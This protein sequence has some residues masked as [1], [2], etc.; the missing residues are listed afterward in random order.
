[1]PLGNVSPN[2]GYASLNPRDRVRPS[3]GAH[4]RREGA[5]ARLSCPHAVRDG[6]I[7]GT[8]PRCCALYCAVMARSTSA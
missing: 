3:E 4:C 7:A 1:M 5:I 8:R 6:S 2:L